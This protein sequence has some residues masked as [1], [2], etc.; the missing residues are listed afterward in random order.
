M[1]AS[2]ASG[3][4]RELAIRAALGATGWR[5]GSTILMETTQLV[6]LGILLGFGLAWL[7]ANTIR[8]FLYG[9][10]PFD[11]LTLVG[12][13]ALILLLAISISLKPAL[14]AMRLDVA[15]TLRE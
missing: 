3:R 13:S 14:A 10:E 2:T 9:I 6:G 1:A 12:V 5:L 7:G 15:R 11:P 8:A 4:R